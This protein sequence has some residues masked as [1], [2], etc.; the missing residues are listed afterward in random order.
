MQTHVALEHDLIVE[1]G[2][3]PI[4][5]ARE[6]DCQHPPHRGNIARADASFRYAARMSDGGRDSRRTFRFHE[7]L[8]R[9]GFAE[10]YRAT[11]TRGR[12]ERE[13][14]VKLLHVDGASA[15]QP[16]ERLRDEARLL[17]RLAHPNILEVVDL[18]VVGDNLALVT[19]Y[20]DGADLRELVRQR[21]L[22]PRAAADV[23]AQVARALDHALHALGPDGDP[24]RL[25][26]RDVKPANIRLGRDGR[27]KL[28]DFGMA[29]AAIDREANTRPESAFGSYAFMAP[30][31]FTGKPELTGPP[32]D[33]YGLGATLYEAI[34]GER[35]WDLTLQEVYIQALNR[36]R[37]DEQLRKRLLR[38][39]ADPRP[40]E[41]LR[42]MLAHAPELRP[43]VGEVAERLDA[44]APELHG[45]T[46][47]EVLPKLRWPPS[48]VIPGVLTDQTLKESTVDPESIGATGGPR[49]ARSDQVPTVLHTDFFTP[50]G[51]PRQE[52][53]PAP[54]R[55][56][57]RHWLRAVLFTLVGIIALPVFLVL[58]MVGTGVLLRLL[59]S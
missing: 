59:G 33:V 42:E 39:G 40:A 30:E 53:P 25:V 17:R 57:R 5:P 4:D 36:E 43:S 56:L 45:L 37:H 54:T 11:V 38:V 24:L 14:A 32:V 52:H 7:C 10:V 15:S 3:H 28:L 1:H 29:R 12:H 22:P 35:L 49:P 50:A 48:R 27:V 51:I 34:T 31:Q 20:V 2:D 16:I 18:L 23:V 47:T 41:V 13:V 6:R 46:L 19:E 9:G 21:A 8:G 58:G 26:H 44:L 55:W